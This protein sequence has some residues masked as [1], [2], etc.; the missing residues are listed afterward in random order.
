[1]FFFYRYADHRDL[2]SFPT[3]RSSDLGGDG[4]LA[5][6]LSVRPP[7]L[8]D[9]AALGRFTDQEL[10]RLSL[11]G[12][13]GTPMPGSGR[14]LDSGR[15]ASLVAFPRVVPAAERERYK[16]SPASAPFSTARR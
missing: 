14:S 15:A 1:M 6:S 9:L 11:Q 13:P 3:R 12:R 4:P 8:S 2:H 7:A 10:T 5:K 16:A